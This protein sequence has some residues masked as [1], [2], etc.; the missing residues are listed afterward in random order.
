[1]KEQ[2]QAV[3]AQLKDLFTD[4]NELRGFDDWDRLIG[5]VMTLEQVIRGLQWQ[6]NKPTEE[7][8]EK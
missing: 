2:I 3:V 5:C 7:E 4:K 1:M 6:D 8:N